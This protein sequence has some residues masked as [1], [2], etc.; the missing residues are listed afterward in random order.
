[1]QGGTIF[2][3]YSNLLVE[4]RDCW[5]KLNAR[6]EDKGSAQMV[7]NLKAPRLPQSYLC[8]APR[9]RCNLSSDGCSEKPTSQKNESSE[10]FERFY[11]LPGCNANNTC[12]RVQ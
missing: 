9:L 12:R 3:H 7:V 2:L 1:M 5:R 11:D 6:R 10:S 4:G 8:L